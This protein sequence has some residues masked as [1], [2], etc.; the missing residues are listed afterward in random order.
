MSKQKENQLVELFE[1]GFEE[2]ASNI[3][4]LPL[5][6]SNRKRYRILSA[7]RTAIG[8]YNEDRAENVAF[9]EFSR[10]FRK[11]GLAVPEIYE[12]A[13]ESDIYLEEDLGNQ[14]LFDFLVQHR[15]Q[16]QRFPRSVEKVYEKV[17]QILPRFQIEAGA[18]LDYRKCYPRHSFDRQSISWDLNYFKYYFLKLAQIPFNEQALEND[19]SRFARFLLKAKRTFFLY[20]DFQSRN[21]MVRKN[22]PCFIDYQGGRKGAL[23]Y[24]IASLL[25][26]AKAD[27]PFDARNRLL[28]TY[29][30]KLGEYSVVG[31]DEFMEH[32]YAYV[33]VRIMQA[34]GAYGFR[35]FY[36]R[37]THFLQSVPYA[38]RNLEFVLRQA[39]FPIKIPALMESWQRLVQS[40]ML[41]EL[42]NAQLQTTVRIQ[43]FSYKRG[44]PSDDSGHGGGFVFDCRALPNPGRLTKYKKKTGNDHSVSR[45]LDRKEEVHTFLTRVRDL[46]SQVIE[47]Y[48]SRNFSDLSVAFGCTGGQHRSVYCA[49]Q[50]GKYI[51]EKYKVK[52]EVSHRE[53]CH[54]PSD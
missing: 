50:L 16:T 40:T 5:H 30:Q 17:V 38:I 54:W 41:R 21:I 15:E 11:S 1:A 8:V 4:P 48:Q 46:V 32:Y 51:S 34:M 37:K 18:T 24:D 9:I 45:F 43:S 35:G 49:N 22:S 14:T 53:E 7:K 20:R 29:L 31:R 19:F 42:G 25:F 10:H 36:E 27:L 33:L 26:D 2:K 23:Q 3:E 39:T 28:E 6:G 13:L 12:T 44:L 52:V 47:N